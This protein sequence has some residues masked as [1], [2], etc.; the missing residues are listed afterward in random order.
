MKLCSGLDSFLY[1]L[2]TKNE[3]F[4]ELVSFLHE[5]ERENGTMLE[6][7]VSFLNKLKTK[8][9]LCSGDTH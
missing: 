5:L 1:K 2:D 7:L 4:S 8:N 3:M 6:V 9:E